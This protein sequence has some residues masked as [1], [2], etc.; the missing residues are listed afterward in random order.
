MDMPT[1]VKRIRTPEQ[2]IERIYQ[3]FT[4]ATPEERSCLNLQQ[5][6]GIFTFDL[7]SALMI[8]TKTA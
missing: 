5:N 4:N 8:G 7:P 6:D 2:N 1:W 3:I